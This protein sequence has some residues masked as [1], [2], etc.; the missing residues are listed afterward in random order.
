MTRRL[1]EITGNGW[2]DIGKQLATAVASKSKYAYEFDRM[3]YSLDP[4]V[5]EFWQNRLAP[6]AK[7]SMEKVTP[8]AFELCSG[9]DSVFSLMKE[10]YSVW[11]LL[12]LYEVD[13]FLH[14]YNL[15]RL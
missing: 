13:L 5:Q 7:Y 10:G 6:H 8:N 11:E 2:H 9:F 3:V 14:E 12:T 4:D 1:V 15:Q